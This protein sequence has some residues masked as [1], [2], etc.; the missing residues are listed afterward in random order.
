MIRKILSRRGRPRASIEARR[1]QESGVGALEMIAV[2]GIFISMIALSAPFVTQW[3]NSRTDQIVADQFKLAMQGANT[4]IQNNSATIVAAANPTVVYSWAQMAGSMPAGLSPT[5]TFGQTY[6]LAIQR[7]GTAPNYALNPMLQTTGGQPIPE[8]ELRAISTSVGGS[9][10]YISTLTPTVATGAKGSWGPLTLTSFGANPG[11]GRLAGALFYQTSTQA[12]QYLYRV[13]VPGHPELN[14]MQ[15]SVDMQSN[16]VNNAGIVNTN[17][18]AT[19]GLNANDMPPTWGG[20]IRTWDVYAGGTVG[21]GPGG[22]A[23]PVAWMA[24]NGVVQG[25]TLNSTGDVNAQ[26]TVTAQNN[27]NAGANVNANGQ[28]WA[29]GNVSTNGNITLNSSGSAITNPGRMHIN[30]GENLYLQPWSGGRTIVG[31]GGGS[32]QLEVSGRLFANEYVQVNG[33]AQQGAGCGPNG[34]IANSGNGPLFCQSGVWSAAG[35]ISTVE[36]DTSG[37]GWQSQAVASCPAS[38]S[39]VGGSCAMVRGGDGRVI[40]PQICRP[41]GNGWFCNE[42]NGGGCIAYA[43]C[44][45]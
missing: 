18:L 42:Q 45:H 31:G 16:N 14:Q 13:S 1:E 6:Q 11:A 15:T 9:G 30:S 36:V 22:G 37:Q 44:A 21:V 33:W 28:I 34:M 32:G 7:T 29:G 12:N 24:Q 27:V 23:P 3:S 35:S 43:I 10:G 25:Q 26:G 41:N 39:V 5:N 19:N 17:K 40:Q 2:I 38:Y 20:G 4:F 8:N